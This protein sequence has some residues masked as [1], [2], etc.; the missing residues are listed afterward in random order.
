MTHQV[1]YRTFSIRK[2]I[3]GLKN[4]LGLDK[5]NDHIW[6]PW[7]NMFPGTHAIGHLIQ[8]VKTTLYPK[9]AE[10]TTKG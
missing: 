2:A 9:K 4:S 10:K 1:Y 7:N 6:Y 8:D 5:M 3:F